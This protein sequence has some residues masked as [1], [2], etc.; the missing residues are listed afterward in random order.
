ME[1]G[2]SFIRENSRTVV[3]GNANAGVAK[4]QIGGEDAV[5]G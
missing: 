1:G 2:H 5:G 3:V 4:I